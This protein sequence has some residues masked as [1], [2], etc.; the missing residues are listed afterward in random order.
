ME[1]G[2]RRGA[3]TIIFYSGISRAEKMNGG[4]WESAYILEA[5]EEGYEWYGSLKVSAV[6]EKTMID[7]SELHATIIDEDI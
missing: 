2:Y 3:D 4:S 5:H 1:S 7:M 6:F